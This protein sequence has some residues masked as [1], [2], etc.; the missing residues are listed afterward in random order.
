MQ[1]VAFG[2]SGILLGASLRSF[3]S[4][5]RERRMVREKADVDAIESKP[6]YM[7]EKQVLVMKM[8]CRK[9]GVIHNGYAISAD[10]MRI[11]MHCSGKAYTDDMYENPGLV[12]AY[13]LAVDDSAT[14]PV[15]D[16]TFAAR[17]CPHR[18]ED[19]ILGI[20]ELVSIETEIMLLH[21]D[22]EI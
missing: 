9:C 15:S 8:R 18:C 5:A 2:V 11:S 1:Y 19:G 20:S 16:V 22:K 6:L 12:V 7:D 10:A 4:I 14:L 13:K 17:T 21:I 3:I